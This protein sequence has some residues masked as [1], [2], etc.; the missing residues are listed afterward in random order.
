[1]SANTTNE[2]RLFS[3]MQMW[4]HKHIIHIIMFLIITGTP[5]VSPAFS[6]IAYLFGIPFSVFSGVGA[7]EQIIYTGIQVCRVVH[8]GIAVIWLIISIPFIM[9]MLPKIFKWDATPHK[10]ADETWGEYIKDGLVDTKRVYIDLQYP[11][12]MGKYN[13]LQMLVVWGVIAL[14]LLM[15]GTGILLWVRTAI[16]PDLAAAMRTLHLAGYIAMLIFLIIHIYL[17]VHPINRAGYK[18]MF[19]TGT[20]TIE[21][22]KKKHPGLFRSKS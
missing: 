10:D 1:M 21:H 15:I 2:I 13:I 3:N 19:K 12:K 4:Y 14:S 5:L 17:A 8:R 11:K 18:A 7:T 9:S 6:W 16:N 20:D 22:A